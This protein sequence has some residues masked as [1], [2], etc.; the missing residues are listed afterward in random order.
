MLDRLMCDWNESLKILLT[1]G[2]K[3]DKYV[4]MWNDL[5]GVM[6]I[7]IRIR[8]ISQ[9]NKQMKT[10]FINIR[11]IIFKLS[12]MYNALKF[13]MFWSVNSTRMHENHF[14][15]IVSVIRSWMVLNQ[16]WCSSMWWMLQCTFK[17]WSTYLP[18]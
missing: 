18:N 3:Y 10:N 8:V 9:W 15:R 4:L 12:L 14:I 13:R 7:R 1:Y 17:S 6:N 5:I 16:S 2:V 11:L